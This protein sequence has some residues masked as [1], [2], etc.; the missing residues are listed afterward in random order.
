MENLESKGLKAFRKFIF[1]ETR[2]RAILIFVK[3]LEKVSKI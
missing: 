1:E 2:M 3:E